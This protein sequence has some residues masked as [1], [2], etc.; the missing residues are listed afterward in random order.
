MANWKEVYT[1]VKNE[2]LRGNV[3]LVNRPE[4]ETKAIAQAVLEFTV[5]DV[6]EAKRLL[7][8]V[9]FR[10][11]GQTWGESL[12]VAQ[13]GRELPSLAEVTTEIV[14]AASSDTQEFRSELVHGTARR[15][16]LRPYDLPLY[17]A[18][19]EDLGGDRALSL[20]EREVVSR[21]GM[22]LLPEGAF[23]QT[24]E[25]YAGIAGLSF[26]EMDLPKLSG[27]LYTSYEAWQRGLLVYEDVP[28]RFKDS[29][30]MVLRDV[31]TRLREMAKV[32]ISRGLIKKG[33]A[34]TIAGY[35]IEFEQMLA[36][37]D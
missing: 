4:D 31:R 7:R 26:W 24:K 18:Q 22:R 11:Y 19:I 12:F 6:V 21:S 10:F 30:E 13:E 34:I 23:R 32:M 9:T 27:L 2:N 17:L 28:E 37:L 8:R 36:L 15:I 25:F 1:P 3:R 14:L 20:F 16:M 29:M 5:G 35:G 33:E